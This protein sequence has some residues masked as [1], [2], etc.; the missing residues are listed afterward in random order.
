L[1]QDLKTIIVTNQRNWHIKLIEDLW[2]SVLTLK[3][4]IG[5]T[6]YTLVYGKE[7]RL[8]LHLEL[9]AFVVATENEDSKDISPL[10]AHYYQ[11]LQL[12]EQ[13]GKALENMTNR[14]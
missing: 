10:Q 1:I 14:Q 11:L 12:E 2:E 3:E 5:H 4:R 6:P 9:N 8:P 13:R 7:A